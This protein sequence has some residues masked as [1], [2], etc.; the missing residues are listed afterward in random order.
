MIMADESSQ[1]ATERFSLRAAPGQPMWVVLN[2]VKA[3]K[4]AS[5]EQFVH[6]ILKPMAAQTAPEQFR[7]FRVLHPVSPNDDGTYT[8]VFLMD[9][10]VVGGDYSFD[11][12]KHI[13]GE[14]QAQV[15][16]QLWEEA[17]ASPQVG[18]EVVQSEW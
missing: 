2:H 1:A 7:Q 12:L 16:L 17:L 13:Y 18:Y 8:Y 4:R 11:G 10:L 14:E 6:Q 3:D 5:F 15:Y 9:P